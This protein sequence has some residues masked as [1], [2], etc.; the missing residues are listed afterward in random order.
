MDESTSPFQYF[1]STY[2]PQINAELNTILA[3]QQTEV[4]P[5]SLA[6]HDLLDEL[7]TFISRGGKRLRPLLCLLAHQGYGGSHPE[8]AL[9][10]AASQELL[11]TYLLIHDDII[12]RDLR[13]W[14]GPNLEAVYRE[15][16]SGQG[17]E[18]AAVE[19]AAQSWALLAGDICAALSLNT[20]AVS[21]LT[22]PRL[23]RS[24]IL[25]QQTILRVLSG[26][27]DDVAAGLLLSSKQH[28][29]QDQE[30]I[31]DMYA[32]KTA[33]YSFELPLQLGAIAAGVPW[34]ELQKL[35]KLAQPL[36]IAFQLQ[37]DLLD[38]FGDSA[39]TGKPVLADIREGKCT[40]LITKTLQAVSKSQ[41]TRLLH[42]LGNTNAT[43]AEFN[44]VKE[45]I[46]ATGAHKATLKLI[47]QNLVEA[48]EALLN[49][50]LS[51]L[52]Q[53]QMQELITSLIVRKF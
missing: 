42:I 36:G 26:E 23:Q 53:R 12:D 45:I 20:V 18:P 46:K 3:A 5:D 2:K 51:P 6:Y 47:R 40:V 34:V 29:I 8:V 52:A 30:H 41:K 11:H 7:S 21:G 10:L 37:D 43:T 22:G 44:E 15:H 1:V 35:S 9:K 27:L 16:F 24:L 19:Q 17:L 38:I 32:R 4:G 48:R 33:S 13:R 14:G 49:T 39:Q 50:G 31:M 28:H 25:L